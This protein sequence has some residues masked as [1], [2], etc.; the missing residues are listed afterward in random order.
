M[1]NE[2][3]SKLWKLDTAAAANIVDT[4]VHIMAVHFY[5]NAN[6]DTFTLLDGQGNRILLGTAG[7][8]IAVDARPYEWLFDQTF[9]GLR[10]T[11]LTASAEVYIL[12]G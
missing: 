11:V 5:P 2:R 9:R 12:T 3:A 8:T 6:S 10:L 1:A 4:D 7:S